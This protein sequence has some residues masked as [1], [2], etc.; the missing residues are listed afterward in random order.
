[1]LQKL[2]KFLKPEDYESALHNF[3]SIVEQK[4]LLKSMLETTAREYFDTMHSL[5]EWRGREKDKEVQELIKSQQDTLVTHYLSFLADKKKENEK[6]DS[7]YKGLITRY[8]DFE[9]SLQRL[10]REE[11]VDNLLQSYHNGKVTL[12]ECNMIIKALTKEKIRYS[13]NIV[14]NQDGELLIDQRSPLSDGANL[15]TLPG[16]HVKLGESHE[17]AARRE[18]AEETGFVVD[19]V[20]QVGEYD[21][22]DVHIEYFMTM[23][24]DDEQVS[25]TNVD[26]TR[27][28]VFIPV[29]DLHHYPA[30]HEN[31]WDNVYKILGISENVTRI[32]KAVA[33]GLVES[34]NVEKYTDSIIDT[35]I[36][37]G[38]GKKAKGRFHKVMKEWKAGTLKSGSGEPVTSREQAIAIALS[39]SGQSRE[40]KQEKKKKEKAI[41]D[42]LQ[43]SSNAEVD[44]KEE[45][46]TS[47]ETKDKKEEE[48]KKV[49][50]EKIEGGKA[51]GKTLEQIAEHHGVD[52]EDL[53]KQYKKGIQV[54]KEHTDDEKVAAEIARDHLWEMADYYDKLANMEKE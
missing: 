19:D 41:E 20:Y 47:E 31:M 53:V 15:W 6:L 13:D 29:W 37:K 23:V 21:D 28:V 8:P 40:Q 51:E 54:E 9:K 22:G 38:C 17:E 50:E 10:K 48:V 2:L 43:K 33:A 3:A 14:F 49:E 7:E 5:D 30:F 1:M 35:F 11:F 16:G 39:E 34:K 24:D 36:I 4:A 18:L 27:Y 44:K 12:S 32:K 42:E 25:I 45:G 52:I 46:K 26:E